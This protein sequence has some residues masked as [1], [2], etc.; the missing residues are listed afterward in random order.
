MSTSLNLQAPKNKSNGRASVRVAT[1]LGRLMRRRSVVRI[2]TAL[3]V[4]TIAAVIAGIILMKADPSLRGVLFP[5]IRR[6]S[7]SLVVQKVR[8]G[9]PYE[10]PFLS[11][12]QEV[13]QS[14]D[15]FRLKL[16][17]SEAGFFYVFNEGL[18]EDTSVHFNILYPTPK[19]NEGS[20]ETGA[21]QMV[22]TGENEFGNAPGTE[23][24][25][26]IWTRQKEPELEAAK[27]TAFTGLGRIQDG[28]QEQHLRHFLQERLQNQ[29]HINK[30]VD[31]KE[32]TIAATGDVTV[33]LLYLEHR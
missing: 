11:S 13:F 21:N 20:A 8:D 26:I 3:A 33:Y 16:L 31:A 2:F 30:D 27:T 9:K 28:G 25:W 7:Y 10:E 15:Q 18:G 17:N 23:K 19:R 29:V 4:A 12:G 6:I 32:T 24:L 22:E 14:G 1:N 5:P